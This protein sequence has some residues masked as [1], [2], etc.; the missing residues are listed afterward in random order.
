MVVR[1]ILRCAFDFVMCRVLS[2]VAAA[3]Q[4]VAEDPTGQCPRRHE[5]VQPH[6]RC[7]PPKP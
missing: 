6:H 7:A 3:A 1:F 4:E 5:E 2:F